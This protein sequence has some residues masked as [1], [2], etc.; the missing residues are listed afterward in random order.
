MPIGWNGLR[1]PTKGC[2]VH[3]PIVI[4]N[5]KIK[6]VKEDPVPYIVKVLL[7]YIATWRIV[8]P[9]VYKLLYSSG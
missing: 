9:N 4:I 7:T 3:M 5:F 2:S 6:G 8:D 1:M